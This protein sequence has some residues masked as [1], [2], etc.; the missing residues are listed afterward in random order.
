MMEDYGSNIDSFGDR[1][2]RKVKIKNTRGRFHPSHPSHPR[3]SE[4]CERDFAPQRERTS[5]GQ[6]HLISSYH[7]VFECLW[8]QKSRDVWNQC[9]QILRL[10]D[11]SK[12]PKPTCTW[13]QSSTPGLGTPLYHAINSN[14][15][16]SGNFWR[17][18]ILPYHTIRD[19][20][21]RWK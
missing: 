1:L 15:Y 13:T 20:S 12:Q 3:K 16:I 14:S 11:S 10:W 9:G 19:D 7:H 18:P 5:L 6:S 21:G 8:K 17:L 4:A 2:E